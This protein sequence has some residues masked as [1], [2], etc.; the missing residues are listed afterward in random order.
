MTKTTKRLL[1]SLPWCALSHVGPCVQEGFVLQPWLLPHGR[2]I[3][4]VV[5]CL[6][7]CT[8]LFMSGTQSTA[9]VCAGYRSSCLPALRAVHFSTWYL[10]F[11]NISIFILWK[12]LN[13]NRKSQV[14]Q[15]FLWT[16]I[17]EILCKTFIII[18][19]PIFW[20]QQLFKLMSSDFKPR[21]N[22]LLKLHTQKS[23][24]K[25]YAGQVKDI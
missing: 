24:W 5:F 25:L 20:F 2:E 19:P 4:E 3:M 14:S 1:S 11:P 15:H 21:T 7:N 17:L 18:C 9:R 16:E 6:G 8:D 23:C 12:K 22:L 13:K 10:S